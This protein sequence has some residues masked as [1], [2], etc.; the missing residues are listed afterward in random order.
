MQ[1]DYRRVV[2]WEVDKGAELRSP[3]MRAG[4]VH[5]VAWAAGTPRT[6]RLRPRHVVM[7]YA[8]IGTPQAR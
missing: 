7:T 3:L 4:R 1:V 8:K 5:V 2:R 6:S